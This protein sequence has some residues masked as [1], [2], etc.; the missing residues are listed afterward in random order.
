[1]WF[2]SPPPPDVALLDGNETLILKAKWTGLLL[3]FSFFFLRTD[4]PRR[5]MWKVMTC[6]CSNSAHTDH[7][8][9]NGTGRALKSYQDFIAS[10]AEPS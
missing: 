10:R 3:F 6:G 2:S 1:M 9:S 5:L 4:A 8:A 7:S